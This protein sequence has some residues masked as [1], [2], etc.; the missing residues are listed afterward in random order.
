MRVPACPPPIPAPWQRPVPAVMEKQEAGRDP[1]P[2]APDWA[3]PGMG[4][5]CKLPAPT[6]VPAMEERAPGLCPLGSHSLPHSFIHP[7][8]FPSS[9]QMGLQREQQLVGTRLGV[10]SRLSP[11]WSS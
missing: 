1:L 9:P 2:R 10:K 4:S 8:R 6:E 3:R 11:G 7:S 5:L